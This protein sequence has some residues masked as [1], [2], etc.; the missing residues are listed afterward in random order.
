MKRDMLFGFIAFLRKVFED[1]GWPPQ[2]AD[3]PIAV[4]LLLVFPYKI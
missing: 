4:S 3:I 1:C 2:I